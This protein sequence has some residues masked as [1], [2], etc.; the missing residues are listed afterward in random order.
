MSWSLRGDLELS[1]AFL[2]RG[3]VARTATV[4]GCAALVSGLLL[5]AVTVTLLGP[6]YDQPEQLANVV[7]D[8]GVRMGYVLG[9]VLI[10]VAPLALLRQVLRLGTAGREQRLAGLRLAGATPTE[11]H[12]LAAFEVGFPALVGGLLGLPVFLGLRALLGG[13]LSS[14]QDGGGRLRAR[15]RARGAQPGAGLR[16]ARPGGTSCWSCSSSRRRE[17]RREPGPRG[18]SR[19]LR[20]V[21]RDASRAVRRGPGAWCSCSSAAWPGSRAFWLGSAWSGTF[22]EIAFV[23]LFI[24]GLLVLTP[25]IAY[26]VGTAVASRAS[27]P[28]VLLAASRLAADPRPAGRAAAAIG[29]IALV[30]GGGGAL[31]AVLPDS[32]GGAGFGAVEPMYSVPIVLAGCILLVAL[33]LV[34][35]TLAVH[36][37]E[38]LM[39]RKRAIASLAAAGTTREE[40]ERVQRWEIGLVAIPVTLIGVL[41]GSVP[42]LV[43]RQSGALPV[44]VGGGRRRR[45][46]ARRAGGP[47]RSQDHPAVAASRGSADEPPHRLIASDP[48]NLSGPGRRGRSAER[49]PLGPRSW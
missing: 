45:G 39:D 16:G 26:R 46:P 29:A 13:Q 4:V 30:A 37:A 9:L 10:C 27:R 47:G 1:A 33:V 24:L 6:G 40:L 41:I 28:H 18:R 32:Y 48:R 17:L 34:V 11:V 15:N 7:A 19:S 14:R 5:V 12:R 23:A 22:L 35:V 43:V 3:G 36:A 25:W 21:S 42:L 49:G 38:S 44:G 2:R 20:S 8:P 31:V